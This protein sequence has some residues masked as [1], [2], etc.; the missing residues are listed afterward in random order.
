MKKRVSLIFLMA[1]FLV[2]CSTKVDIYA[3]Y[4]EIPVVYGLIEAD[5]DTN[6]VKVTKA[7]CGNNDNP[8][9]ALEVAQIYDSSE[10]PGKL[11][12]FIVELKSNYGQPYRPTG[13]KFY[14]DTLTLHDKTEGLFYS[15]HQKVYY[16]EERFNV[17]HGSE[18]YH[19]KLYVVK[20]D[21]DTVTA[22]T[23]VVSG[24]IRVGQTV[25]GFQSAPTEAVSSLIFSSTEEAV[26]YE[27]GMQFRYR[28]GHAG[29][30]MVTKE[31]HWSF[32]ART[33]GG[34]EKVEN[35]DNLYRVY[36]SVNTL[37]NY[38]ERAIG[39]DTVWDESHP[40]VVRYMDDMTVFI[41][42]AGEDFNNYYQYLQSSQNGLSLSSE[43]TNVEGGVGL[44]S[45]R[46]FV[47]NKV[48]LSPRTK[49][50][51]FSKP[52]GFREQ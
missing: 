25:V 29:Q 50:D 28:E 22:E 32:G 51:L 3:D 37:F 4:K 47:R 45:S 21:F 2:S 48:D 27:I 44:F 14:L 43:Y 19:Y 6:F 15:P 36:Y 49:Y 10:Y 18:R 8:I 13:R 17:N 30:P 46:I 12:A 41:A 20:P 42:A 31:V 52:W 33:L 9:N 26:I 1:L 35:T 5:S 38:L 24:D 7:F 40:N 11:D 23:G 39:N 34:Y 16:T